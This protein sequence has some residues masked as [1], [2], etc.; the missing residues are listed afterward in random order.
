VY[1]KEQEGQFV[2][3]AL[4]DAIMTTFYSFAVASYC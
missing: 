1:K 2:Q 4:K 3:P